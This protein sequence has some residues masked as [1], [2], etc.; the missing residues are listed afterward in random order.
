MANPKILICDDDEVIRESLKLIL[1]DHYELVLVDTPAMVE[2][3]LSHSHDIQVLFL[4]S[5]MLKTIEPEVF[6]K[7]K[8]NSPQ[9]RIILVGGYKSAETAAEA[10]RLGVSTHI[11]KPFKSQEILDTIKKTV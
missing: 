9:V 1:A 3:V 2:D 6:K 10:A 8:K 11:V 4:N 7:I 5:Q